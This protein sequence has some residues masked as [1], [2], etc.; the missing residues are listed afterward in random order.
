MICELVSVIYSVQNELIDLHI[1]REVC[2]GLSWL[3]I[4]VVMA[5][6]L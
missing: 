4:I 5:S 2:G 3:G 1:E 6:D